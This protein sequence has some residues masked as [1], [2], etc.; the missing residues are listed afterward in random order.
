MDGL[1]VTL[2]GKRPTGSVEGAGFT[3][4]MVGVG[5]VGEGGGLCASRSPAG[6]AA[7]NNGGDDQL[8]LGACP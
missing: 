4:W 1:L 5:D 2:K 8:S 6:S 3:V 7:A